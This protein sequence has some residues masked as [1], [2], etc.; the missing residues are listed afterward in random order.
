MDN[1]SISASWT[2]QE[3][4]KFSEWLRGMLQVTD[5]TVTFTK[6]DGTERIM[7]CTLQ[8][9]SLP[10]VEVTEDKKAKKVNQDTIAVF[11]VEAKA[12]RSF[13]LKSVNKVQLSIG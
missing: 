8:P 11:D 3:W 9:E 5:V 6:K 10:K 1:L 2:N 7:K 12:W 13:T 4:D